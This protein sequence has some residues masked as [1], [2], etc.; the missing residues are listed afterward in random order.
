[1]PTATSRFTTK[2]CAQKWEFSPNLY[3]FTDIAFNQRDY[4]LAALS[5]GINRSSTGQRYRAGVSFGD[6]GEILRGDI[7]L[8]YGRQTPN[9]PE[10]ES[11]TAC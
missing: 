1:M 8:G 9:S 6:I 11:S 5:D 2:R 7:S 10:L 3:L 4:D